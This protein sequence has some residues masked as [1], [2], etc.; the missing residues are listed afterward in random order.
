MN[1]A[2]KGK[3]TLIAGPMYASKSTEMYR[4]MERYLYAKKTI[5]LI[6]PKK[7]DRGYFSHSGLSTERLKDI[8][9]IDELE[10]SEFTPKLAAEL[11]GNPKYT[12]IFVDEYFMIPNINL[13]AKNI[14]DTDVYFAGLLATSEGEIFPE[15]AKLMPFVD[16]IIKLNGVCT[17]CGNDLG[18]MSYYLKNDKVANSIQVGGEGDYTCLCRSC[19]LKHQI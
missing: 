16:E 6:R 18:T 19:W 5:L 1:R 3:V 13:L 11:L 12:A 2:H 4:N 17:E 14:T 10:I 15:A 7:D 8:G 9:E